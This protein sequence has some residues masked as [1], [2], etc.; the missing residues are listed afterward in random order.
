[1]TV[2]RQCVSRLSDRIDDCD[3]LRAYDRHAILFM[4]ASFG[5]INVEYSPKA[6]AK[7]RLYA[8]MVSFS[9]SLTLTST[10]VSS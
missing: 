5:R 10:I 1:M 8:A 7:E 6:Y 4:E 9:S 3:L 2:I